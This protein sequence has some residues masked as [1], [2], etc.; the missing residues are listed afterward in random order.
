MT[1]GNRRHGALLQQ[2]CQP[3]LQRG[4][5]RP[6]LLLQRHQVRHQ[7]CL[8]IIQFHHLST[9]KYISSCNNDMTGAGYTV[10]AAATGGYSE[11]LRSSAPRLGLGAGLLGVAVAWR[12]SAGLLYNFI[13]RILGSTLWNFLFLERSIE[14][15]KTNIPS[16]YLFSISRLL[17]ISSSP[18]YIL[19]ELIFGAVWWGVTF[20]HI[21]SAI[22]IIRKYLLFIFHQI[23]NTLRFWKLH[24][25]FWR[26]PSIV[27]L[28]V[29]TTS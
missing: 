5:P 21:K 1:P 20:T 7:Y 14:N 6:H 13:Q 18:K 28:S 26:W 22:S 4:G 15:K 10:A 12:G 2:H 16:T 3:R 29:M 17:L 27:H 11:V 8:I 23:C 24:I 9:Q 25:L 19:A